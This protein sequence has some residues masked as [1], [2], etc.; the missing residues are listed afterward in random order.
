MYS[1]HRSSSGEFHTFRL[2]VPDL[3]L[4]IFQ[5]FVAAGLNAVRHVPPRACDDAPEVVCSSFPCSQHIHPQYVL[6]RATRDASELIHVALSVG[7]T[8]PAP[9]V[10]DFDDWRAL[11]PMYDAAKLAGILIV[12][13]PGMFEAK[14]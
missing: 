7:A 9:G 6:G 13:R 12:L 3:W 4:D 11:K 5:K 8:N 1:R 14:D 10:L 2:P